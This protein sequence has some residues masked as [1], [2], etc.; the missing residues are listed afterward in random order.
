MERLAAPAETVIDLGEIV[1]LSPRGRP[2]EPDEGPLGIRRGLLLLFVVLLATVGLI[3]DTPRAQLR[4]VILLPAEHGEFAV[5]GDVLYLIQ[6]PY[7]P[8]QVVAYGLRDGRRMW[9]RESPAN[10]A[11]SRVYRVGDR[12]LLVPNPCLTPLPVTTVAV[13]TRTGREVWRR[14]GV[15]ERVVSGASLVVMSRAGPM[16]TCATGYPSG[17]PF[18]GYWDGVDARTGAVVW[19][20]ETP[21][22]A[23]IS[24]DSDEES[25][26]RRGVSVAR[27]G[28]VTSTDLRTGQVTGQIG[29]PELAVPAQPVI[30]A[31]AAATL[32]VIGDQVLV[33]ERAKTTETAAVLVEITAYDVVTLA[34]RWSAQDDAGPAATR[35]GANA[36]ALSDCGPMLCLVGPRRTV[37][38]NPDTGGERWHT[39]LSLVA[40][41]DS[42]ALLADPDAT[43][44]E[45]PLGGLTVR[46]A[47]TGQPGVDLPGWRILGDGRSSEGAPVLGRTIGDR[48]WLAPLDLDHGW[49]ATVGSAPG[50][51]NSC[52]AGQGYLVCRRIDG[53]VQVWRAPVA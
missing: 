26:S 25:A 18:G 33:L 50:A 48:T 29:R 23:R 45:V 8:N 13:D 49:A 24:F 11:Y 14:P 6:G 32:A 20:A 36:V 17:N 53:S 5:T 51:Y 52:I 37:F 12:T 21:A 10:T 38:L 9:Q 1:V 40:V 42:R 31:D 4:D 46:D 44:G 41:Q 27:D 34:R 16:S 39:G 22:R 3:G 15:P 30:G 43:A 19:S 28:T 47:R 2:P 7:V 35:P